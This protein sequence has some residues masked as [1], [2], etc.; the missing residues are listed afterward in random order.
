MVF[1][2]GRPGSGCSTFLKTIANL[3]QSFSAVNGDISYGGINY[4]EMGK[5]YRGEVVYNS[6]SDDHYPSLTVRETLLFA[7][8]LKNP[9]KMLP[10]HSKASFRESILETTL[11]MLGISHTAET[12]VGGTFIRGVSGGEKK[13]VSIAEQLCTRASVMSWDNR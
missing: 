6:E 9:G 13:R 12:R 5:K 4:K 7:L 10:E 11:K 3:H 8:R 2:L 1:V